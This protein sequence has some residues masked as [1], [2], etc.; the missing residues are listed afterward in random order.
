MSRRSAESPETMI[1]HLGESP[2]SVEILPPSPTAS[3]YA[4]RPLLAISM[5]KHP[6]NEGGEPSD[7]S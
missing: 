7:L 3:V 4:A 5:W 1:S 2:D 6:Q